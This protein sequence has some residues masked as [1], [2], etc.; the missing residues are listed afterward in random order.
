MELDNYY[1]A[2]LL[3]EAGADPF[4][5][6]EK[7]DHVVYTP[8]RRAL[9]LIEFNP[10]PV[11]CFLYYDVNNLIQQEVHDENLYEMFVQPSPKIKTIIDAVIKQYDYLRNEQRY[12]NECLK[13]AREA[14]KESDVITA[15]TY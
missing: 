9:F 13:Q 4:V 3:L 15:D 6:K 2:T 10:M 14:L 1:Y 12:G 7:S 8:M 11:I 5:F